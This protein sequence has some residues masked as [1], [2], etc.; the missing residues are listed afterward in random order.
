MILTPK[1]RLLSAACV[2]VGSGILAAPAAASP[3]IITPVRVDTAK[4]GGY[5]ELGR[6]QFA[7]G[8]VGHG[9]RYIAY[10][11]AAATTRLRVRDTQTMRVFDIR[12]GRR[13]CVALDGDDRTALVGCYRD[14]I[15][16]TALLIDLRSRKVRSR[17]TTNTRTVV[18]ALGTRW[19]AIRRCVNG[20]PGEALTCIAVYRNR[21]TGKTV[22]DLGPGRDLDSDTLK[23]R[24]A[25]LRALMPETPNAEALACSTRVIATRST[26]NPTVNTVLRRRGAPA[27]TLSPRYGGLADQPFLALDDTLAVW[28]AS[29]TSGP[30]AG[31]GLQLPSRRRIRYAVPSRAT[32]RLTQHEIVF[33]HAPFGTDGTT[34]PITIARRP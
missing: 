16:R 6:T 27:I 5:E 1:K 33:A 31:Y 19:L 34:A 17:P 4:A 28:T 10:I 7:R 21:R 20:E 23:P 8:V 15:Q 9:R 18:D 12:L 2:M 25:T 32:V 13:G 30:R 22:D 24:C 14:G 26:D 11:P 3:Q 29:S